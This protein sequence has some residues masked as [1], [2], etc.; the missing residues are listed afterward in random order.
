MTRM[1][2]SATAIHRAC[3]GNPEAIEWLSM[4]SPYVH[5]IDDVEDGPTTS[6]FRIKLHGQ[7]LELF[8]HP[9]FL[10]NLDRLKQV[11][12]NC[13]NAYADV[14]DW[15]KSD[16]KWKKEFAD[17]YRH[18]GVEVVLTVASICAGRN[19]PDHL[20]SISAEFR[21]TC[22]VEHHDREGKAV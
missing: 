2:L 6:D 9:F 17:H 20:R 4:W 22:W 13:N 18:F 21:T 11:V 7:A 14:V 10:K 19:W 16:Q 3:L 15:E 1:E 8:T 12:I 5:G